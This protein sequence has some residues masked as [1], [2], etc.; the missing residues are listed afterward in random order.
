MGVYSVDTLP[1]YAEVYPSCYIINTDE[2]TEESEHWVC[3]YFYSHFNGEFFC[4]FGN[5][6]YYFDARMVMFMERDCYSWKYNA[7][8]LQSSLSTVCG[9]HYI[10]FP[11]CKAHYVTIDQICS[12]FSNF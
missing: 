12:V 3:V 6:P 11:T 7:R 1:K 8:R 9:Q 4:S 5:S 2:S 10:L